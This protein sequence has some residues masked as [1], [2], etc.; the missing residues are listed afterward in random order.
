MAAPR[1]TRSS[2]LVIARVGGVPVEI[3]ASWL[4]LAAFI[5]F[6]RWPSLRSISRSFF[7]P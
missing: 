2:G 5:T 7:L 4:L 6:A 3:G 1:E